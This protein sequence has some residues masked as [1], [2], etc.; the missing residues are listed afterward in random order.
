MKNKTN[1]LRSSLLLMS[2]FLV[3]AIGCEK[4]D[5]D[6]TPQGSSDTFTDSRDN[7]VYKTVTIGNQIWMAENLKYLPSVVGAATGSE[8]TPHYYVYDYDGNNVQ[9]AKSTD[10]YNTYGVLYNWPA[11]MAGAESSTSNPSGVQCVCPEG[12]HLPSDAEWDEL[13]DYLGGKEIAGGKLKEDGTAHWANPNTG[14]T[15]ESRFTSLPGGARDF[16]GNFSSINGSD[17]LWS[18]TESI[19]DKAIF[20]NLN[21]LRSDLKSDS[22]TKQSGFSV[23]CVKD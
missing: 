11:A 10:N 4:D 13:S 12:W 1:F 21:F 20:R 7:I 3:F 8:V 16:K 2:M 18:S 19:D 14:A 17:Y 23:R 6:S 15:N 9:S 5:N 22:T